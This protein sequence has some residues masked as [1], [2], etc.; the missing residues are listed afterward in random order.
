[1]LEISPG[2]FCRLIAFINNFQANFMENNTNKRLLIQLL[3]II[4][5]SCSAI[6]TIAQSN[7]GLS[8][9]TT[10]KKNTAIANSLDSLVLLHKN[11]EKNNV[12]QATST[13]YTPQLI[14]TPA[15]S[16]LQALPGRLSGLYTRQRSGVQSTDDPYGIIEFKIRGQ[17]P[18]ILIDGVPRDFSSIEPES[19]ESVTV[20]KDGIATALYGQRS[21]NNIILVTTKRP[22][23]TPFKLSFTAQH[24]LQELLSRTKPLS[25]ANYAILY[26]EARN[27]DGLA[28]VYSAAD[29]LAYQNCSDPL[30]HPDNDYSKYF[31]NKNAALDRYNVNIQSGNDIAAFY[32]ALDYQKEG[33]FFNTA[34]LN[35]YSTNAGT[36][37]Y[38]VRSN[39][40]VN[41]NKTLSVGLNI[42][43]RIQNSN[44]PGASTTN[45]FNAIV[46]TPANAYPVFNPDSSLGGNSV[47]ANNIYGMLNK[48]GYNK[49]T[50]RD[51]ASDLEVI[52]KLDSWLPG[53]WI[54]G[55]ISYNNT[56]DQSVNRSKNF[57]VYRLDIISGSPLYTQI[58]TNTAQPNT[59]SLSSRRTYT[60]G[61]VSMGYDKTIGENLWNLLILADNQ[62]TTENLNLPSTYANIAANAA[63]SFRKKYLAEATL[64]YGGYNRYMPGKRF[65]LFYAGALGWDIAKEGFMSSA[66]WLTQLKPRISYG[67]T[68]N[69]NVGY[70]VYD[71]YYNYWGS[72]AAYYF[73]ATPALARG[74]SEL[75]LANPNATWEKAYK[76]NI[77]I[78]AAFFNN[79]LKLTS[80]YFNDTYFDLMQVR[81]NSISLIGQNYPSENIGKNRYTGIENDITW[82]AGNQNAGYFLSANFSMLQSK[83]LYRDEVARLYNYQLRTG[84]PV[85]Q[86]F[87]YIA[88]GF[89]Q[90]QAEIDASP[91]V[92]GYFPKPGDIKYKD[93]NSDGHINQFDETAIGTKKPLLYYGATTG[94]NYK[95]FDMS[96]SV[97][98]VA[99]NDII[100]SQGYN[101]V[102]SS[103][104]YEFQ[105]SGAGQAFEQHLGRWTPSN[106]ANA[107]YPRL[108]IGSNSNNQRASTFWIRS[109]DYLRIQ[110]VDIGYTLPSNFLRKIKLDAVRLFAN[111]FNLYS[112]DTQNYLD[113]ESYNSIFPLRR[114]FNFGINIKL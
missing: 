43:G 89:Y 112:F 96:I 92:D 8:I 40:K 87:G 16:F 3:L 83:V 25:A 33:G 95:G 66:S 47:Y 17:I 80:E 62:S 6:A 97:Q 114:T 42:F 79:K 30:F 13:I 74:F 109:M 88:N 84:L 45:V 100:S 50:S 39:V 59:L 70:Y 57:A 35:S 93:L 2:A 94:F 11:Q 9:Y 113:P 105:N 23:V 69:A 72:T 49:S 61:K 53:L 20:L 67:L 106:A 58:G 34:N 24:G 91:I 68:G 60:Y 75:T 101:S 52:Q 18:L 90:S 63:Y 82:S 64:S 36:D 110:N 71:Q 103:M 98:G 31:L 48:A 86:A 44:Q 76:L 19:I 73:G 26:N 65:G 111:G 32:V 15:P 29:I 102:T 28:P 81:G 56:V 7:S 104:E 5:L 51:L 85:G 21:S 4:L 37:R 77:G 10:V 14:T 27:N 55:N 108:S 38:I 54:K 1:M 41:L 78:D 107:S 22:T 12:L 99:H 46:F